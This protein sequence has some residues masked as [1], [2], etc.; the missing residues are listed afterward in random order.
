MRKIIILIQLFLVFNIYSIDLKTDFSFNNFAFNSDNEIDASIYLFEYS[1]IVTQEISD[2][3]ILDA[4]F[5]KSIVSDYL[6]YTDFK[7]KND[8]F[9]FNIGIF[10]SFLNDSSRILTPGLNYGVDFILPGITL[11]QL[12][13]NNTIPNTSPLEDG[14]NVNNYNIKLGFYLGNAILSGNLLS[15]SSTKGN[16]LTSTS[17]GSNKYFLNVD[18]FNKYS[19]YRISIDLGWNDITRKITTIKTDGTTLSG[20]TTGDY[21]AGSIYFDS[22]VTLLIKDYLTIDIGVLLNLVKLPIKNVS[23]FPNDKLYWGGQI[24]FTIRL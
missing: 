14:V 23:S 2:G 12:K 9:G 21:S 17:T 18:M 1:E 24:G 4:G 15:E 11:L 3:L 13:L 22:L 10:S 5:K 16:I 20:S 19:K 8:I 7:I 6:I